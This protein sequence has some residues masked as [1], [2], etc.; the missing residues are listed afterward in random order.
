M[1]DQ[2]ILRHINFALKTL[3]SVVIMLDLA[4][5]LDYCFNAGKNYNEASLH[6]QCFA[7]VH[8]II[9]TNMC[10]NLKNHTS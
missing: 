1:T 9:I 10:Q 5:Q 2:S 6:E 3:L 4:V 7:H 8:N